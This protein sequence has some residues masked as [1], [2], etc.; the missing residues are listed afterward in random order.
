PELRLAASCWA[1]VPWQLFCQGS[2]SSGLSISGQSQ[3][4][5]TGDGWAL[6]RAGS[7][8]RKVVWLASAVPSALCACTCSGY[9]PNAVSPILL[10]LTCTVQ[11]TEPPGASSPLM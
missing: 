3:E 2:L 4:I 9:T 1:W 8:G 5:L 6:L 10:A 11:L 7:Y